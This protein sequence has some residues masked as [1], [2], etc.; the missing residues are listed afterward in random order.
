MKKRF[1]CTFLCLF[2]C[3]ATPQQPQT[4]PSTTT[5]TTATTTSTTTETT[6][7]TTQSTINENL[8]KY[9]FHDG[10]FS[11][12]ARRLWLEINEE[13]K[14]E[15]E[16]VGYR[17]RASF[18][19]NALENVSDVKALFSENENTFDS[20]RHAVI[21]LNHMPYP[22]VKTIVEK[23]ENGHEIIVVLYAVNLN[24]RTILVKVSVEED[25]FESIR[26]EIDAMVAS[27]MSE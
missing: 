23:E 17:S 3:T 20:K 10:A 27:I 11:I 13:K 6:S 24:E 14:W 26:K 15:F 7:T 2:G 8:D 25:L 18:V 21:P 16:L 9:V 5:S 19:V 1:L 4:P 12:R 22:T